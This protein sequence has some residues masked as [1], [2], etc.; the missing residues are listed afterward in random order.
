MK[1][2]ATGMTD[3]H[4]ADLAATLVFLILGPRALLALCQELRRYIK[5]NTP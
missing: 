1:D 4:L 2:R 5:D 3:K